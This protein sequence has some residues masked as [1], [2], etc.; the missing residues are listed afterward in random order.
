[1][2]TTAD[3]IDVE[4][5]YGAHN[6]APLNVVLERGAGA[7]VVDVFGHR[8]LDFLSGYSAL[9]QGHCHPRIVGALIA[10][11]Q[12]L[13]LTSRAFRNDQFAPLLEELHRLTGQERFLLMNSGAEAVE[14]AIKAA[15]KWG[16]GVKGIADGQAEIVVCAD[17]FH[18]RTVSIV[19]F[20]T[21]PQYREGFGPF[22]PGFVVV[23]FGDSDALARAIT[24]RT[25]AFL[26][27]P[28]QGEAGVVVPPAGYLRDVERICRANRVLFLVDEIQ[29]GLGRAGRLFAYQHEG[30]TP[31]VL[32]IGKALG[33][34]CY[35]VSAVAAR[36]EVLDVFRP[37]DHGSTFGA[38]PLACAV[39]R[40]ALAVIVDEQL[41]E[42]SDRLGAHML[43]A[44]RRM[45]SPIVREVRGRG[46]WAGVE[47][48]VPA[49]PFCDALK[50]RGILCKD[51]RQRVL[52]FAP[53][54][55]IDER[56]LDWALDRI[57]GVLEAPSRG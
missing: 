37:G 29:S 36:S 5:E 28:I 32:I 41:P 4:E 22:T 51:T 34:G 33:G 49:R 7:W 9:N 45:K 27:E 31:D 3:L 46:L 14:T 23:P 15:R 53:P 40:A 1:M 21:E 17:N 16:Y 30:V 52:R 6:Y 54:L 42:R 11:A 39:A 19:S 47:L 10:Q 25:C 55:V 12:R 50:V 44:L 18:G 24:P 8:Y 48:S 56:D 57:R 20:S 43:D 26:V 2:V 35:P 13:T 38:N